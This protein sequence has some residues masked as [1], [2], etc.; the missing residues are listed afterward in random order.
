MNLFLAFAL[1][2]LLV[3]SPIAEDD[4]GENMQDFNAAVEEVREML[5]E[6]DLHE[7]Q[8]ELDAIGEGFSDIFKT[9]NVYDLF[10]KAAKGEASPDPASITDMA[11]SKVKEAV[12]SKIAIIVAAIILAVVSGLFE[13][14]IDEKR[15]DIK[16]VVSLICK[17]V[18][19]VLVSM[20]MMDMA[21]TTGGCVE[22]LAGFTEAASPVLCVMLTACGSGIAGNS[23]SPLMSWLTVM[24]SDIMCG[25]ILTLIVSMSVI[26]LINGFVSNIRLSNFCSLMKTVIKWTIGLIFIIYTAT[27]TITGMSISASNGISFKTAKFAIDK[28]VPML[29]A[30]GTLETVFGMAQVVKNA[31]GITSIIITMAIAFLPI[32][33]I[34]ASSLAVKTASALC[35]PLSDTVS[36][37]LSICAESASYFIAIICG[38]GLM[39]IVTLGIIAGTGSIYIA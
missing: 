9:D 38:C 11:F 30:G 23:I 29:G 7:W 17:G 10:M 5:E 36:G 2:A 33:G 35:Q 37:T 34:G 18:S 31:G 26:G 4:N 20:I 14:L 15:N 16:E 25:I 27:I 22:R 13:A 6:Y 8:A 12:F 3:F 24:M 1:G 32:I 28:L 39:L 19:I 21:K